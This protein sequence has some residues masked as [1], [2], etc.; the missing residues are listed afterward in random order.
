L[1]RVK[2]AT[3]QQGGIL[4]S[5]D[6]W[7]SKKLAYEVKKKQRGYYVRFDICGGSALVDEIER[8]FRIDDR[9]LKYM[10]VMTDENPDMESVKEEM[11]QAEMKAAQAEM[12]A[13]QAEMEAAQAEM[14]AAQAE[15]KK[16][17]LDEPKVAESPDT[18]PPVPAAEETEDIKAAESEPQET[19]AAEDTSEPE[20]AEAE[21]SQPEGEKEAN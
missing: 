19:V 9:V 10:T 14:K 13:A 20:S 8:Y 12:E 11:A 18:E 21:T 3:G 2:D 5:V 16:D 7:G 6:D 15:E 4:V 1:E 17:R